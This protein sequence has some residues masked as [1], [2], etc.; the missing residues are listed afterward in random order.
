MVKVLQVVIGVKLLIGLLGKIANI[1]FTTS[2]PGGGEIHPHLWVAA[3]PV[4]PG[5]I[6]QQLLG[7][8]PLF[9]VLPVLFLKFV[10]VQPQFPEYLG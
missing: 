3:D 8:D 5:R 9:S 10:H 1:A 7:I 2:I 4:E 6:K